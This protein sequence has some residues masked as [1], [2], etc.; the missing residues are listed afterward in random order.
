MDEELC[1]KPAEQPHVYSG[2]QKLAA[3]LLFCTIGI[4]INIIGSQIVSAF[5]LP[6]FLDSIGTVLAA[7]VGGSIPG[8]AVGYITNVIN[9]AFDSVAI[10]Y[11]AVSVLIAVA[12][13]NFA[14]HGWFNSVP[15]VIGVIFALALIGGGL[16]SIITSW[17]FGFGFSGGMSTPLAEWFFVNGLSNEFLAQFLADFIFDLG[18]KSIT[19]L[20]AIGIARIM[21]ESL[22]DLLDCSFWQQTP[23]SESERQAAR[24]T[25]PRLVSVRTKIVTIV[26]SVVVIVGVVTAAISFTLFND[27]MQTEQARKAQSITELAM[28]E[29]DADRVNEFIELGEAAPGYVE[30]EQALAEIRDSFPGVEYLYVYQI[31]ED[32][33]HVVLDPDTPDEPGSDPGEVLP[34]DEAF[35]DQLDMLLAG[36]EIEPV[37]SNESYGW[38]LSV[39]TP[40]RDSSGKCVAYIA[41]DVLM[42]HIIADGTVFLGKIFFLFL[43]FFV[44]IC[45]VALWLAEY[46]LILP[47]NSIALA[48]GGF[49][50][51]TEETRAG[52]IE[53]IE[54][55]NI[56][57]GDEVENLYKAVAKT[58][59][60]TAQF[61]SEA[62]EQAKTIERMQDSLIVV[63]AD[64]V[65]SRDQ[66]TGDHVI[67]TAAYCKIIM[68]QLR[69]EGIYADELTDEFISDV[70]HSAPLHDVG[71]IMVSDTILNKPGRLTEDEYST[72]KTHTSAG[73]VILERAVSA[74]SEPT[75]LDEAKNLA[76]FHHERWDGKGYPT[77]RSG[78]DIPLSARI[79]AV[80]DVFDAL[81]SKRSYK[82]G[83]PMEKAFAII[84]EGAGTQ[85]DPNVVQAFL[86][87]EDEV[88]LVAEEHGDAHGMQEFDVHDIDPKDA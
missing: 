88:R 52:T 66:Y 38:L 31:R 27:S 45:A 67:K 36:G 83:F 15:K 5:D 79:M 16:S 82:D 61:I 76:E 57:T 56:R 35:S 20:V 14:K 64:L 10:Y 71:K 21:P 17:L 54:R 53:Q 6:L 23:L 8:I 7:I 47:I 9:L 2:K 81:V 74:V 4:A 65:E 58:A 39:Y 33:C 49:A 86:D 51:D 37:V 41:V 55:L 29:I 84:R 87:A 43:A 3:T 77:G 68:K 32:G 28:H 85:F 1:M 30:T 22:R 63:M 72:M 24:D 11:G 62:S 78:E 46:S 80:A 12:A 59:E 40:M 73:K 13:Y 44:L 75:Y 42:N 70:G 34:F 25:K 48:T 60:D 18:D 69:A 19:V 50:Y 26:S